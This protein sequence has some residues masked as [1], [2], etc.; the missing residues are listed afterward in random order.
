MN[1]YPIHVTRK[2]G[3]KRKKY[4]RSFE[5]DFFSKL[6]NFKDCLQTRSISFKRPDQPDKMSTRTRSKRTRSQALVDDE[7]KSSVADR[8]ADGEESSANKRVR[9]VEENNDDQ[10]DVEENDDDQ[11]DAEEN[12]DD[13]SDD[14][15]ADLYVLFPNLCAL[16][17]PAP[18]NEQQLE[19]KRLRKKNLAI[20]K[21]QS[22]NRLAPTQKDYRLGYHKEMSKIITLSGSGTYNDNPWKTRTD[23]EAIAAFQWVKAER[24]A[25]ID[26]IW[27]EKYDKILDRTFIANVKK[28]EHVPNPEWLSE[29]M[30]MLRAGFRSDWRPLKKVPGEKDY[31]AATHLKEFKAKECAYGCGATNPMVMQ[32][33]H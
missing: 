15:D 21:Q 24:A 28:N 23:R 8:V 33:S 2:Q 17:L 10:A 20:G 11:A 14:A 3:K 26:T 31:T 18:T 4:Y 12:D 19:R 29:N 16:N 25:S 5:I 1:S 6:F 7:R 27:T 30:P 13:D 32:N 9:L 22:T